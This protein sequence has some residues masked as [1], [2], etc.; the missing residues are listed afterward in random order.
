MHLAKKNQ[1]KYDCRVNW[2][3]SSKGMEPN[4]AVEMLNTVKDDNFAVTTLI[5]D[6]DT[7]TMANVQQNVSH[8]FEKEFRIK[9]LQPLE[10]AQSTYYYCN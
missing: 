1:K 6:D 9:A 7:T 4:L 3:G 8:T 5:G 10:T 2:G